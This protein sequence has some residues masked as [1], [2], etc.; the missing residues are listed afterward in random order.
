[1][2]HVCKSICGI[3]WIDNKGKIY[4]TGCWRLVKN[5]QGICDHHMK[6]KVC[7]Q[8]T[9]IHYKQDWPEGVC[10]DLTNIYL[11]TPPGP[12]FVHEHAWEC[13]GTVDAPSEYVLERRAHLLEQ[14]RVKMEKSAA[15][16]KKQ[17]QVQTPFRLWGAEKFQE[18]NDAVDP[19]LSG[20]ERQKA[21]VAKRREMWEN[22]PDWQRRS[23]FQEHLKNLVEFKAKNMDSKTLAEQKTYISEHIRTMQIQLNAL[24]KEAR[25]RDDLPVVVTKASD[26]HMKEW[27]WN[28]NNHKGSRWTRTVKNN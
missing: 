23:Y 15:W 27:W 12:V 1:M 13:L 4:E 5:H 2:D 19:R 21:K 10:P 14:H 26:A 3:P 22:V 18:I 28:P 6:K 11:E 25:T 7:S 17:A 16:R 9:I 20:P 8:C 24:E